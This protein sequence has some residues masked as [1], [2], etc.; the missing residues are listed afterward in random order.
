M[1]EFAPQ[2]DTHAQDA[3]YDHNSHVEIA[4][5]LRTVVA[6]IVEGYTG[7]SDQ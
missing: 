1:R 5:K 3:E 7:T 6:V 2:T 4:R